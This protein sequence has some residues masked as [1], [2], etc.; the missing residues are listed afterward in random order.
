MRR[1][2]HLYLIAG[3]M[4]VGFSANAQEVNRYEVDL[5]KVT[6]DQVEVTFFVPEMDM[7]EVTFY[8]PE[9]IPG[10]Y[11]SSDFGKFVHEL[12]AYNDQGKSLPVEKVSVNEYRISK[13]KKLERITY[14]VEDTY[15]TEI[16]NQ[17]FPM[18]GTNIEEGENYVISTP[19]FFG[20]LAETRED[21]YEV[22]IYK[23]EGFYGS[24]ALVPEETTSEK[25]VFRVEDYD[26][27]V[28][29]PMMYNVPD[30][31]VV[32]MGGADVLV[33]V[34]SPNGQVTAD[35]LAGELKVLLENQRKF[36][37]GTLPV[38]KYAFIYYFAA[39][40]SRSPVAGALEHSYSS[41][42]YLP[43]YNQQQLAP[44]LVDIA[45]HEFFH[46]V[47][48]LTIHSEEIENFNFNEPDLSK[49]L[50]LY[51]GVTE[52]FAGHV[53]VRYDMITK[54]EYLEK[55]AAKIRNSRELYTDDLPFT[56]LSEKAAGEYEDEYGNV[57]EKGAL[58]G[59]MLDIRLLELSGGTYDLEDLLSDLGERY[60]KDK[61]FEDD[62]LFP[63]ITS[64]TYPEIGEFFERYVAG[65]EPLP[66]QEYFAKVGVEYLGD[67]QVEQVS[68]GRISLGYDPEQELLV[69]ADV[70]E[71]NEFGKQ[72][73]YEVGDLMVSV[74]GQEL[75]PQ[76]AQAVV[77]AVRDNLE[78]GDMLN[79]VV[80][81]PQDDGS[82]QEMTLTA[83]VVM[84]K[85][86]AGY[87][88]RL[89]DE[90][91]FEQGNLRR[92]WMEADAAVARAEDVQSVDGI[93]SAMYDVISGPAG[94]RDWNRF[95]SLYAENATMAAVA[96]S[97]DG[98]RRYVPMTP[99]DYEARNRPFFAENN[100]V[101]RE[102]G[103]E[104]WEFGPVTQVKTAYEFK[105]ND[106]DESIQ[107]GVNLVN[108]VHVEGR[109]WITS[110]LWTTEGEEY[111]I[112]E[113]L[114]K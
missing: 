24:T 108:L 39:G 55:L 42:Y 26:R 62:E 82:F 101:E 54:E 4:L 57:Y 56:E 50:W 11:R 88:L 94:P 69:I 85:V 74:M 10:T 3:L 40:P 110:I 51:E 76:S 37:G 103:R 61:A 84:E 112:P 104:V 59:A 43:E 80:K 46:I 2:I 25:D 64:M 113:A 106:S 67:Q 34:Y 48:P 44:T 114:Q 75:T 86:S 95:H 63:V 19:G 49:H 111:P 73:G 77:Q 45:A 22:T 107:R 92:A 38:D 16:E 97:E 91:S 17:V 32:S 29:S 13:A 47:T 30:T 33:S 89:M 66:F 87:D 99:E 68:L 72:M 7:K 105:V 28:D 23:P 79:V 18:S 52:Y 98:K 78:P 8:F 65:D 81:R 14:Q 41:F 6:N 109:W 102:L 53:Q 93:I 60:G 21:P 27:L 83:P 100:F 1:F 70:S 12:T 58:I 35:F 71:M 20:Y 15:D 96:V 9:I 90:V 36:L 31:A 5:R